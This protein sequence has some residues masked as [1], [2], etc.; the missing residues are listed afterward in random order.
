MKAILQRVLSSSV[1]IPPSPTPYSS[2][3][4]GLVVLAGISPTDTAEDAEKLA[5]KILALRLWDSAEGQRWK[6]SVTDI[7]GDVMLVSQFTLFAKTHRGSK[8]DFH[9]ALGPDKAKPLFDLLVSKVREKYVS[10][11]V[12]E[13]VFGAMMQVA[14][15]NDGPVTVEVDT[16]IGRKGNRKE[17]EVDGEKVIEKDDQ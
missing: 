9:G 2:A 14:L 12:K 11:R 15:V 3:G 6:K 1:L 8:P 17:G 13:G 5:S 16:E 7:Q 10:E 4:P